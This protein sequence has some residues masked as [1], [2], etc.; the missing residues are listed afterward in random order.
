MSSRSSEES[1]PLHGWTAVPRDP[2]VL[3]SGSSYIH[4]PS[5]LLVKDIYFP[6]DDGLVATI[7]EYAKAKLSPPT[8][9]HS[10]RVY[11]FGE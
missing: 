10:M 2:K 4:K 1:V 3:L 5:A 8:F 7:Q 9:H 11:Y 6:S